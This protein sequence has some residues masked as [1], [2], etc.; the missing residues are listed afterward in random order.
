MVMEYLSGDPLDRLIQSGKSHPLA[1]K[2]K[3]VEQGCYALG[4]AHR[5]DVI[6]RDVKP[7]NVIVQPDGTGE[8]PRFRNRAARRKQKAV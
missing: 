5:N 3:I 1:Y 6:H 8:A 7:A 2:L 4:Y